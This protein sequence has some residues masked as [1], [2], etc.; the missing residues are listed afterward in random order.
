V[1]APTV[2]IADD[3][4]LIR[5]G[6]R[7]ALQRG[8]WIVCAEATDAA[9]AV[10]AAVREQPDACLL[11]IR[12]PGGGIEAAAEIAR[13]VPR[14]AIVMLTVSRDDGD[15]L[16]ALRAGAVGYLL[17]DTD[18]D[19]L[20]LALRGVLDGE[21]ALPRHLVSLVIDDFRGRDRRTSLLR[22]RGESL[23]EQEWEVVELMSE[24]FTTFQIA[25]RLFIEP[26]AVRA[27]VASILEKLQV[28]SG[29]AALRFL[30]R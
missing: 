20:P 26:A 13:R 27:R 8:G 14:S 21:A 18:P 1:S 6:V 29:R 9:G 28:P 23:T 16:D 10:E 22:R 4:P 11:D 24:G 5:V 3:H 12:M 25:D 17:K 7:G 15:L 30:S 2:L 19:R